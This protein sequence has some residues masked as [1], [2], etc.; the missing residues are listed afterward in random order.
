VDHHVRAGGRE[1]RRQIRG[2]PDVPLEEREATAADAAGRD[3]RPDLAE[4]PF[5]D[6]SGI[7]PVEAV[8]A[9]D[10]ITAAGE[11]FREMRTDE[12]GGSSDE[13]A[14]AARIAEGD[15]RSSGL[16][17]ASGDRQRRRCICEPT[18]PVT[19]R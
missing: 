3:R 10:V 5:L 8:E 2:P 9:R 12:T 18:H 16:S 17:P 1:R 7:E 13:D 6:A 11:A 4:V 15:R 19:V 14:H